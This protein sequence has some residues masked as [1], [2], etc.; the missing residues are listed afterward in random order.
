MRCLGFKGGGT[1][2]DDTG[3][4]E[5]SQVGRTVGQALALWQLDPSAACGGQSGDEG[6]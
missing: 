5:G 4:C 2:W 3:E 6:L 1:K